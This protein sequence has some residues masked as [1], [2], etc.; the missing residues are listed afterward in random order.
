MKI[1]QVIIN[2]TLLLLY[3]KK[4]LYEK[5]TLMVEL[6]HIRSD[7]NEVNNII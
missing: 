3:I 1:K 2:S 4:R 5:L 7:L 6:K